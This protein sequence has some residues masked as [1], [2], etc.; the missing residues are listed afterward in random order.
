LLL[1]FFSLNLEEEVPYFKI[2]EPKKETEYRLIEE[3]KIG[4]KE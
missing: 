3:E 4:Q 1:V 2:E